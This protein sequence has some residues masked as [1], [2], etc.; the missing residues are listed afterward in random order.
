MASIASA[1]QTFALVSI[2]GW[3]IMGDMWHTLKLYGRYVRLFV[4][5]GIM[6]F[7]LSAPADEHNHEDERTPTETS[8]VS[9]NAP[10]PSASVSGLSISFKD[11]PGS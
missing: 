9:W 7:G 2:S 5:I 1:N 11:S 10:S 8:L 4:C 6:C 3:E